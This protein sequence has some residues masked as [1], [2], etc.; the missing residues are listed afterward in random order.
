MAFLVVLALVT[1]LLTGWRQPARPGSTSLR[2][3][4][5]TTGQAGVIVEH[6]ET[7]LHRRPGPLRRLAAAIGAGTIAVITGMVLAIVVSFAVAFAVIRL[8][9]LLR[10]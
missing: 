6:T 3:P 9:D 7:I 8:T 4:R 10:T 1:L 2:G 5:R